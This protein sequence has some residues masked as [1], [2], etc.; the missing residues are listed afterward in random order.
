MPATK[1]P[2]CQKNA[3]DFLP[4]STVK[5]TNQ[6]TWPKPPWTCSVWSPAIQLLADGVHDTAG[7]EAVIARFV[8]QRHGRVLPYLR[9]TL[10]RLL[11]QWLR[12]FGRWKDPTPAAGPLWTLYRDF[13]NW[14]EHERGFSVGSLKNRKYSLLTFLRWWEPKNRPLFC[15]R[16]V[17][18][19]DFLAACHAQ[20][21]SRV[22]VLN[23]A[24]ATRSF[25]RYAEIRRLCSPGLADAFHGPTIYSHEGLPRGPLWP[26]VKRLLAALNTGRPS[27]VRNR[28]I[29][30]LFAVYGFRAGEVARLCLDD[31]DWR[32]DR[33]TV[34]RTKQRR[35][36]T[37]PLIPSVGR[38][39]LRYLKE[40][41]PKTHHREVFLCL[42]APV[43]PISSAALWT[44][45][46]NPIDRAGIKLLH[47]GPH[48]LPPRLRQPASFPKVS[49][50]PKSA[51]TSATGAPTPPDITPKSTSRRY[52]TSPPSTWGRSYEAPRPR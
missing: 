13:L 17:D 40:V 27:H 52:A 43:R 23:V 1:L 50:C 10:R 9:K 3:G 22:G 8:R 48:C 16:V 25:L 15:L 51:T 44:V 7:V 31:I 32:H 4:N 45:V 39:I 47:R 18:L 5:D 46:A 6:D 28:A 34:P 42:L 37:Y 12:F 20:G 2:R 38:A 21:L 35:R 29:L 24:N 30:L 26:E 36:Q 11:K 49:P 41:R 33:I 14:L 19:D